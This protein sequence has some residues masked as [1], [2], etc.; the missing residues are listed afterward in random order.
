MDLRAKFEDAAMS[1][2][3]REQ[4]GPIV[5]PNKAVHFKS[6]IYLAA[7]TGPFELLLHLLLACLR[8][9]FTLR[10]YIEQHVLQI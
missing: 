7:F 8:W 3:V 5:S 10:R 2:V 9:C 1:N 6:W 4:F